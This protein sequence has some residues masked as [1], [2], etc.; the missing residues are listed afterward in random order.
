MAIQGDEKV[1]FKSGFVS[2]IG[3]PN[4]G[5]STLINRFV[6]KKV[7]IVTPKAQTTRNRILGIFHGDSAQIAFFDTPGICNPGRGLDRH[8]VNTAL[9]TIAD[10]DLVLVMVDSSIDSSGDEAIIKHIKPVSLPVF[11]VINKID[12]IPKSK[13]LALIALYKD[14]FPYKE[15][16][17]ISALT[18]EN[19]SDLL[20]TMIRY[21]PIGPAYFSGDTATD[22]TERFAAAEILR[23]KLMLFTR[24]EIPYVCAVFIDDMSLDT[25]SDI[26]RI[27]ATIVVEKK[28]QKGIIIGNRGQMLKKIAQSARM[29]IEALLGKHIYMEIWVK[30]IEN[31]RNNEHDLK[32]IGY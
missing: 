17:P 12:L 4:T 20:E 19:C 11:L 14:R 22:Q 10:S 30:V 15:I 18:G 5:K 2:I 13:I 32:Q 23:E 9:M 31:W 7:S 27:M 25:K 26:I 16:I 8:M 21:I 3:Q 1:P 28:S 24:Q 29:D 6:G